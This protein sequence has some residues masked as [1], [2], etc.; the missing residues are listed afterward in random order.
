MY[1]SSLQFLSLARVVQ[2][3]AFIEILSCELFYSRRRAGVS[4]LFGNPSINKSMLLVYNMYLL[5][6]K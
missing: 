1:F 4:E 3:C 6:N 2:V 5:D